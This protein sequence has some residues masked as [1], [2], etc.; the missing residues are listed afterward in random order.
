MSN[1]RIE[2]FEKRRAELRKMSDEQLKQIFWKLCD[3]VV[4]PMVE[5][6]RTH[7]SPSIERSVL[8]RMGIDSITARSVV[9]AC[10]EHRV[11]GK[12]AGHCVLK[13]S[14]KFK[15]DIRAAAQRI[16]QE[17]ELLKSLFA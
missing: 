11:L 9:D 13:V 15:I 6:S 10:V 17:P 1:E 14:Q 5:A 7:T 8:A 4:E 12:G 3:K 2:K 16:V